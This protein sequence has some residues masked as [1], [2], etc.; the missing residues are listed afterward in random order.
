MRRRMGKFMAVCMAGV[1][2]L[3]TLTGC[4]KKKAEEAAQADFEPKLDTEQSVSLEVAGFMGNFEALDQVI[5]DFNAIYPNV[6]ISYEQNG[7][8]GLAEYMKNNTNVDIFMTNAKNVADQNTAADY[9]YEYC[10]DLAS[11]DVDTS[12]IDPDMVSACTVNGKLVR[13]PLMKNLCGI[14]VNKTLLEKE[15]VAVPQNYAEFTDAC[16]TLK[17]KGYTPIQGSTIHV[18][19]DLMLPMAMN[20]L[21]ADDSLLEGFSKGDADAVESLRPVFEKLDEIVKNGYTDFDVNSTY[22]DDNYDGSIMTFFEGKVPFWVCTAE[23][24]SGMKKRETKSEAFTADPFEYE[25]MYAPLGDKGVYAYEEPWYGFSVNKNS[26]QKEYAI[27]FLRFLATEPE[28]NKLAEIK[29]MPSVTTTGQDAKYD[30]VRDP[31]NVESKFVY[32]GKVPYGVTNVIPDACNKY[33]RGD[34]T[35]VDDAIKELENVNK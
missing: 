1:M 22:P 31:K 6:T 27:E 19:S 30:A 5:N 15:G 7:A 29:G 20:I 17:E 16:E 10:E 32:N 25:Y 26:D 23:C 3:G 2:M 12:A 34:I 28:L 33:G 9:V 4:G 14:V 24:V 8:T 35:S 21:G 18:Y 13:I 11:T